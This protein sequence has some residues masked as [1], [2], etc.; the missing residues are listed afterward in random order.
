MTKQKVLICGA[1]G[2]IGRNLLER[3][4][5]REDLEVFATH[6]RSAAPM[7]LSRGKVHFIQADLT[8]RTA[9]ERALKDKD[10]V[11][12]AAAVT[13]GA[14]DITARP[15][16]HV[17]D[18]VIMNS[19]IFRAAFD[20]KVKH[21]VFFSCAVMYPSQ[22]APVKE[23]DFK[24]QI[25]EKYF[26][27]GWT[28]VYLEKMCEFYA[29]IGAAKYTAIRHSNVYG[30]YDKFDLQRSHVF[31]ATVAKVMDAKSDTVDVWGDGSEKRDLL[32]VS[33]LID[34]VE[35]VIEDQRA[36][37]ELI[38][39]GSGWAISVRELVQQI[40]EASGRRPAVRFDLTKP[41]IKLDV[42]LD[43]D[44]ARKVYGWQPKVSLD[45][46]IR[47]TLTWYAQRYQPAA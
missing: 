21:V 16:I 39:V 44:R 29:R 45:E 1:S 25:E 3:L 41:T 30:P 20:G 33:D 9:V 10:V 23:A 11:I 35:A 17:T 36:P 26:G 15:H 24:Y 31:G 46:G 18:N 38:N 40:I 37:F 14:G 28:K 32:Y 4:S 2:F 6:C 34:F 42:A 22:G 8:E 47:K 5:G 27:A 12:Q 43:I 19:L 7:E 13:S